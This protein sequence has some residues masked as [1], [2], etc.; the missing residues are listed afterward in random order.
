MD[1]VVFLAVL[2]AAAA[3]AGWN[4]VIKGGGDPLTMTA[5]LS[6]AAGIVGVP[7]LMFSGLPNS[8]A[9]PWAAASV[10]IH[11]AYFASLIETYRYGDLGQV[12]PIARGGAPLMTAIAGAT[13]LGE[14]FSIRGWGGILL[15]VS[16]VLLLSF[17]NR[18]ALKIDPRGL[19]YAGLTAL[20]ICGY[21][22]T[23][24]LGARAS[25]NPSAYTAVLFINCGLA[26][27]VY[28]VWRGGFG[29]LKNSLQYWRMGAL[30]GTMQVVSYGVAIWAMTLAPIALVG[31][32]RETSVLFGSLIAV[33]VLKEPLNLVRVAG[34]VIIVGG[35]LLLRLA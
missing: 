2:T 21:T 17:G 6:F 15:L 31:A 14:N 16:G 28:L 20:T 26:M 27:L 34:A 33:V 24:G 32:L 7:L 8:G 18:G 3:H 29:L 30:G 9:W 5:L 25:G 13:L 35:L 4:A 19:R 11:M 1:I 22:L 12:Y 10:G 23:D